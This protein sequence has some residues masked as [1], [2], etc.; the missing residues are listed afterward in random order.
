ME[1]KRK[2]KK[3]LTLA[4]GL[5]IWMIL[6]IGVTSSTAADADVKIGTTSTVGGQV[7]DDNKGETSYSVAGNNVETAGNHHYIPRKDFGQYGGD[8]GG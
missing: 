2:A 5:I 3:R 6:S 4:V 1:T 8:G 7:R